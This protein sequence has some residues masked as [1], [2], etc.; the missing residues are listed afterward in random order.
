MFLLNICLEIY[1]DIFRIAPISSDIIEATP[2]QINTF[3]DLKTHMW[4]CVSLNHTVGLLLLKLCL[5][6]PASK[7]I[8]L[9]CVALMYEYFLMIGFQD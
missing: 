2:I 3:S 1:C 5:A 6:A 8:S 7:V 9:L 4:I